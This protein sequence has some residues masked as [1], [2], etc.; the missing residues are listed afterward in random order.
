MEINA[1]YDHINLFTCSVGGV[2][3]S[4]SNDRLKWKAKAVKGSR[5]GRMEPF[6]KR[7]KEYDSEKGVTI[8]GR[9]TK[10]MVFNQGF[11]TFL[12]FLNL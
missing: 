2:K 10:A 9:I 1:V 3:K 8:T 7:K 5:R 6:R 12:T 4:R 11:R